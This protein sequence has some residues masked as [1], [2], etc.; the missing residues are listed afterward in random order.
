MRHPSRL[1]AL[2]AFASVLAGP[3]RAFENE[4]TGY[5]DAPFGASVEEV[6]RVFPAMRLISPVPVQEG[7]LVLE[8]YEIDDQ[9]LLGAS[10]CKARLHFANDRFYQVS[11]VCRQTDGL[12]EAMKRE[13]GP[14][15]Q[16]LKGNIYW[17]SERAGVGLNPRSRTWTFVDRKLNNAVGLAILGTARVAEPDAASKDAPAPP[18]GALP[19][20]GKAVPD[21]AASGAPSGGPAPD[22]RAASDRAAAG[23]SEDAPDESE[24]DWFDEE[25]QVRTLIERLRAAKTDEDR[26]DL[27]FE[28]SLYENEEAVPAIAPFVLSDNDD[29]ME[30]AVSAL[31]DIRGEEAVKAIGRLL[32]DPNSRKAR[33]LRAI[34]AFTYLRMEDGVAAELAKALGDPDPE[35]RQEAAMTMALTA[36]DS[37]VP[38]L[39]SALER[40]PDADTRRILARAVELLSSDDAGAGA[41]RAVEDRAWQLIGEGPGN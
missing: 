2:L 8:V 4:P 1:F 26:A 40:E 10:D 21:P 18:A 14:A 33:K 41:A 30:A 29:V 13:F 15:T 32:S 27:L 38:A 24:F 19:D 23:G 7:P 11:F 3:V 37:A 36:D 25:K 16:E 17:L 6:R 28:L 35:V 12:F 39:R 5:K 9:S 34:E 22:R 20:G 31:E